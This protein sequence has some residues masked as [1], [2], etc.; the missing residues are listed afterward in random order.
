MNEPRLELTSE[1]MRSLG[2]RIVDQIVEY[3]EAL[4]NKPVTHVSPR[5]ELEAELR[6]PLPERPTPVDTL[7]DQLQ[8][9][10]W[11]NIS[12]VHHPRSYALIPSTRHFDMVMEHPSAARSTPV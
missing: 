5:V 6:E 3:F 4:A 7:L 10:V 9:V 2:Y 1:E 8:R 12:N 11:P